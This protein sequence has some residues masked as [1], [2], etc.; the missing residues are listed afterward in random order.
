MRPIEKLAVGVPTVLTLVLGGGLMWRAVDP[1]VVAAAATAPAR[2]EAARQLPT[3]PS[4]PAR[5]VTPTVT[6]VAPKAPA[7]TANVVRRPRPMT[8]GEKQL[9]YGC[10]LGYLKDNCASVTPTALRR[11][12]IDPNR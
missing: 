1:P 3:Q 9:L 8:S 2:T 5:G 7:A 12:G 11:Q 4:T 10:E 6:A